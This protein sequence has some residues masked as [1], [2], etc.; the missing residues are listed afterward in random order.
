MAS[1]TFSG[2]P[3]GRNFWSTTVLRSGFINTPPLNAAN[4]W[5]SFSGSIS[6]AMP[7]GGRPL[8]TLNWIPASCSRK[9]ASAAR[10]VS[11][12]SCVTSVP[13]TSAITMRMGFAEFP[14]L[15]AILSLSPDFH[16]VQQQLLLLVVPQ[17]TAVHKQRCSC[18]VIGFLRCQKTSQPGDVFRF[19][20]P[21]KWNI[22]KQ[23]FELDRVIQ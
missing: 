20:K 7:R 2:T 6:M 12:F 14:F 8:V 16:A 5:V 15:D 1:I 4:G 9:T 10:L 19:S 22:S 23:L 11:T 17:Q 18:N 21:S 13:S 3:A